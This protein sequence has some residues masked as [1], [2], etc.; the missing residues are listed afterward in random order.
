MDERPIERPQHTSGIASRVAVDRLTF[1]RI[2]QRHGP[3]ASWAVW[4]EATAG[5]KSNVGD[6]TV[7]DPD[8]NPALL[9]TLRNDVVMLGLNLSRGFP[10]AFGNFHDPTS[11]GQDYKIRFAFA[12]TPYHGAY[13]TDLIKEVVM[14]KSGDLVRYLAANNGVLVKNVERLLEEFDD[15]KGP[16]PTL[17][18]FGAHAYAIAAKH[19]PPSRYS[20]LVRVTHYSHYISKEVYRERVLAELTCIRERGSDLSPAAK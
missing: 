12:G 4:G 16:S 14:L 18:T 10:A 15:L 5:P 1:D 17:I 8:R 7:M 2:K 11:R 19:V 20:R 13:M 3:Y 6:L 9:S